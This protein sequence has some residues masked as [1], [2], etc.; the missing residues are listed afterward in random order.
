M[1]HYSLVLCSLSADACIQ[2]QYS[3][4]GGNG[5]N[6]LTDD[7]CLDQC[8]GGGDTGFSKVKDLRVIFTSYTNNFM[9]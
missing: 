9:T 2:F 8:V 3:G 5:N 6:F 4:C 1:G 7:S